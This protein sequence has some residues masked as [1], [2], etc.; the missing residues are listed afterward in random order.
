MVRRGGGGSVGTEM[1]EEGKRW[2]SDNN[3]RSARLASKQE[4]ECERLHEIAQACAVRKAF[5]CES[6]HKVAL[7][8]REVKYLCAWLE[9]TGANGAHTRPGNQPA[10][11]FWLALADFSEWLCKA[12][13]LVS[14]V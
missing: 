4:H 9:A 13:H 10:R 11:R 14:C 6:K 5:I 8:G 2:G 12:L 7:M 1:L 3:V